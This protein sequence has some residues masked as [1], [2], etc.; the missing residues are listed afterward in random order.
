M[1]QGTGGNPETEDKEELLRIRKSLD[2]GDFG[3]DAVEPP[4]RDTMGVSQGSTGPVVQAPIVLSPADEA[5]AAKRELN[6][7]KALSSRI[8]IDIDNRMEAVAEAIPD[9]P[10]FSQNLRQI[11]VQDRTSIYKTKTVGRYE[12]CIHLVRQLYDKLINGEV[13]SDGPIRNV[14]G[15]LLDIFLKDRSI[16][17]NMSNFQENHPDYLYHHAFNMSLISLAI[18]TSAGFS[19]EQSLEVAKGALL[20]D[21]GMALVPQGMRLKQGRLTEGELYEVRKH[22]VLG[23]ALIENIRG[24][25]EAV[26]M[27]AYQHHERMGGNGYPKSRSGRFIHP[28]AKIVAIADVYAA[29]VNKRAYRDPMMPYKAMESVV[30][31]GSAGLLDSKGIRSLLKYMS[32]FPLGSLVKLSSGRIA[33]VVQANESNFTQPVVSVLTDSKGVPLLP[34]KIY[35]VDLMRTPDEAVAEALE[36]SAMEHGLMDGF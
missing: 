32:L 35:Q 23:I 20:A 11:S 30:R 17:L 33:K 28:F 21:V 4:R 10:A 34:D 12:E 1:S 7:K 16:L 22:P 2:L 5:L 24:I 8:L 3:I 31:M 27:V 25:S 15:S 26:T 9:G 29:M 14:A 19:Q 36:S 18:A 6:E 13:V